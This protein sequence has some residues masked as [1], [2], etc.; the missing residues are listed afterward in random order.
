MN[1]ATPQ[2]EAGGKSTIYRPQL[3][4]LRFFAFFTVFLHHTINIEPTGALM[5]NRVLSAVVP[6]I[7]Q[8]CGL[9][10]PLFFF[11]SPF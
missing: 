3:D 8:V 6:F 10:L 9:G 1:D 11:L 7:A 2:R 4:V 5:H